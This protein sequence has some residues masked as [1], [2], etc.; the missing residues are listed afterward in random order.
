MF[1]A[2]LINLRRVAQAHHPARNALFFFFF[3]GQLIFAIIATELDKGHIGLSNSGT[4]N[5]N[6]TVPLRRWLFQVLGISGRS[7][8]DAVNELPGLFGGGTWQVIQKSSMI[9]E[10]FL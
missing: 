1:Y 9:F 3:Q 2:K 7:L 5:S 4:R 6:S 10:L 8:N